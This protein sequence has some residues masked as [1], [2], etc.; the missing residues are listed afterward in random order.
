MGHFTPWHLGSVNIVLRSIGAE[1]AGRL[2][3]STALSSSSQM[4][5]ARRQLAR[6]GFTVTKTRGG[7][8]RFEHPDM[9]GPVFAADTPSDL[10]GL[11][12]LRATLRRKMRTASVH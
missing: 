8:W 7:H 1:S 4:K 11:K 3:R 5:E 2:P 10:R 6:E 9:D 12:N